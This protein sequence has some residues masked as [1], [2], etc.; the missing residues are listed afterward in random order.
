MKLSWPKAL[1]RPPLAALGP[2]WVAG[3]LMGLKSQLYFLSWD[4]WQGA[5]LRLPGGLAAGALAG[6]LLAW[7]LVHILAR[8]EPQALPRL[9]WSLLGLIPLAWL[10]WETL[11]RH[12]LLWLLPAVMLALMLARP[13]V[14]WATGWALAGLSPAWLLVWGVL[15]TGPP[16]WLL[17]TAALG[18]LY[19]LALARR[20]ALE[21]KPARPAMPWTGL[22]L[23]G[24]LALGLGLRLAG[25][26]H[27][28]PEFISHVDTPKQLVLLPAFLR[29]ELT[30]PTSY[31][32]GHVYLYAALGRLAGW[33]FTPGSPWHVWTVGHEGW[34]AYVLFA[35]CLQ[36]SL[37]ALLPLLAFLAAR[38][39]W[40][41]AAG[42]LAGL[43]LALDPLHLTYSRQLMGDVPQALAVWLS[44]FFAARVL[45]QGRWWD[46]LAAGLAAG[47][48]VA[49]KVYGGYVIVLALAAWGLRRPWAG[50]PPLLTMVVGL[51]LG[52]LLLSPL[53]WVDPARWCQD[54]LNIVAIQ[55]PAVQS[56]DPL[57]ALVYA[58]EALVRR[59]G[60]AWM[61][62]AGAGL[63]FLALRHK[64]ADL[65][66]LLGALLAIVLIVIRLR[67]LREWDMVNLTPFLSLPLAAMLA[68][69]LEARW[70][71]ARK[72]LALGLACL[73]LSWQGIIALNDAW[74]AR[75]PATG[76]MAG[77]WVSKVLGPE[78]LMAGEYPVSKGRWLPPEA[79]QRSH[80]WLMRDDLARRGRPDLAGQGVLALERFW[81][82]PPLP[83]NWLR[84]A[85][86][87][88]SRNYCWEN[89]DIGLY[90]PNMPD[91][92]SQIILPH[93][94]VTLPLPAYLTTPWARSRPR[95]LLVGRRFSGRLGF[96]EDQWLISPSPPGV[97]TFAAL[98]RGRARLFWAPELG[99]P[100]DLDWGRTLSGQVCPWRSLVPLRPRAYKLEGRAHPEGAFAWVGL[101]PRPE[102]ALPL[103]LRQGQWKAMAQLAAR[104]GP[105]APAEARLIAVAARLEAGDR[106]GAGQ[107]L[108]K[109]R[110]DHP[111]F[112][113]SYREL[114]NAGGGPALDR[115]L[116]RLTSA[117]A[118]LLYWE[119][120]VWPTPPADDAGAGS[121]PP[122]QLE[123]GPGGARLKLS[124]PFLPGLLRLSLELAAPLSAPARLVVR[125]S[126]WD[127]AATLA[128]TPL[129]AG[130]RRVE[131]SLEV[132]QGP[133]FLE[134]ELKAPGNRPARLVI[135][136]DLG[137][138]F[139]WRWRTL[140]PRLDALP[141]WRSPDIS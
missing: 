17:P 7:G 51:A 28:W 22:A 111:D 55:S 75:M 101:F 94:R 83:Q 53:F 4:G 11:A 87:F 25:V 91:Y 114:A 120:L 45:R 108:A 118:P 139:A 99:R 56:N 70:G 15:G 127:H 6:G 57:L 124:Q 134:L 140:A 123:T 29:G 102:T 74:L 85:Q 117:P 18:A 112:L 119:R 125:S 80:K 58:W 121:W 21:P 130:R 97:V 73:F 79:Y 30:P 27:G 38:R 46:Y 49:A 78:Q 14:L 131:L 109:L 72:G 59:F 3:A 110:R 67:S 33:V 115:A 82:Q 66:A 54:L 129:E 19:F 113:A 60:L 126:G 26:A 68:A 104:L 63:M 93:V 62:L 42:L 90:L 16:A 71:R 138:E 122:A 50:W 47:A 37:G 89:P 128:E 61:L 10:A 41:V 88:A 9:A 23:A 20:L 116:A 43:L 40:G 141:A 34:S 103:L 44:F 69:A 5:W 107:A 96:D 98:G 105:D 100:L 52:C 135:E 24:I 1:P 106:A 77:R 12:P 13:L 65:L 35:R 48:A 36:A 133:V 86:I 136:P 32:F 2:A 64:K 132:K 81:W 92:R 84:P 31:P 137:A 95:D 76:Q 39:L 8:R